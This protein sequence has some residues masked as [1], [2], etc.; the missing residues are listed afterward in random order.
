MVFG[1]TGFLRIREKPVG[2]RRENEKSRANTR[3]GISMN[4][5]LLALLCS[6]MPMLSF[7]LE[8]PSAAPTAGTESSEWV[9]P[10][11][12]PY[13]IP[14]IEIDIVA[15]KEDPEIR[16]QVDEKPSPATHWPSYFGAFPATVLSILF[17]TSFQDHVFL[18]A[19]QAATLFMLGIAIGFLCSFSTHCR[20]NSIKI[21]NNV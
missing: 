14:L 18:P 19:N 9:Q 13:R 6:A 10:E 5:L 16:I 11:I 4:R 7:A 3:K 8:A 17:L 15:K 2:I 21:S 12:S 20:L 1:W